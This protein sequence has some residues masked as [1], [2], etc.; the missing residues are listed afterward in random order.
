MK[1]LFYYRARTHRIV[2]LLDKIAAMPVLEIGDRIS[3]YF[4]VTES[5]NVILRDDMSNSITLRP[6]QTAQLFVCL[7]AIEL[8]AADHWIEMIRDETLGC[9]HNLGW[10][11]FL[12]V[13][14]IHKRRYYDIRNRKSRTG[15]RLDAMECEMLKNYKTIII[16]SIPDI[17]QMECNDYY[18]CF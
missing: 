5:S 18:Y 11:T 3:L 8:V 6:E 2:S 1:F 4:D 14:L 10:N 17:D 13:K 9:K 7:S 16:S 15:I 12:K